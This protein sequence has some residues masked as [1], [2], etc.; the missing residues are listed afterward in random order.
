LIRTAFRLSHLA[1]LKYSD[2]LRVTMSTSEILNVREIIQR[3]GGPKRLHERSKAV[4][5]RGRKRRAAAIA[6]KTI[7]SWFDNGIP[8]KHWGFVMP[9]CG[10][11]AAELHRA[12]EALRAEEGCPRAA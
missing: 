1:I 7:Y 3:G 2:M 5:C 4:A 11:T 6:E 8:E 12:N 10:V 9:E